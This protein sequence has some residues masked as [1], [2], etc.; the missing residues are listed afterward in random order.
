MIINVGNR[1]DIPAF[2]SNLFYNRIDEGYVFLPK[3]IENI[4]NL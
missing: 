1:T 4:R 2:Y 3:I